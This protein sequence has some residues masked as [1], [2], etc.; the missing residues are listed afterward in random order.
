MIYLAMHASHSCRCT[1]GIVHVHKAKASGLLGHRVN[2]CGCMQHIAE[3]SKDLPQGIV[4]D[5]R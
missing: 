3:W 1:G 2:D 4:I 5:D